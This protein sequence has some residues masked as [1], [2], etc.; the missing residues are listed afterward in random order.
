MR[1]KFS[2]KTNSTLQNWFF[3]LHWDWNNTLRILSSTNSFQKKG[4]KARS[5]WYKVSTNGGGNRFMVCTHFNLPS[6]G[7]HQLLIQTGSTSSPLNTISLYQ[8]STC[9]QLILLQREKEE[10]L[11]LGSACQEKPVGGD[12][13]SPLM[14]PG[15]TPESA[16]LLLGSLLIGTIKTRS[17][18]CWVTVKQRWELV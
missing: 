5:K 13:L 6:L 11:A 10:C 15:Y 9:G 16:F 12:C 14:W 3:F 17:H 4:R 8:Q 2:Q 7:V 1:K 18:P